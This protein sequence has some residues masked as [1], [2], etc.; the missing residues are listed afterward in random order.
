VTHHGSFE[1]GPDAVL[2]PVSSMAQPAA[3]PAQDPTGRC[4]WC[5][6]ACLGEIRSDFLGHARFFSS[7]A[8][9]LRR[10]APHG[11]SP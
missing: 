9:C 10:G 11:Q 3:E 2:A 8:P 4:R 1:G 5:S 6:R 7:P